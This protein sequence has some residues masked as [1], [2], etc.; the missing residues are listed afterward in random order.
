M[1]ARHARRDD[2]RARR[3]AASAA[4]PEPP[5]VAAA[6]AP[7][8]RGPHRRRSS[9]HPPRRRLR[10]SLPRRRGRPSEQGV[11]AATRLDAA[12]QSEP[13]VTTAA[14]APPQPAQPRRAAYGSLP[15]CST[16]DY[17]CCS[18][19]PPAPSVAAVPARRADPNKAFVPPPG[20]TPPGQAEPVAATAAAAP[21]GRPHLRLHRLTCTR[22]LLLHRLLRVGRSALRRRSLLRRRTAD[23]SKAFVPP[24]GWVPPGQSAATVAA[25]EAPPA[26]PPPAPAPVTTMASPP[27]PPLRSPRQHR[28]RHRSCA[29]AYGRSQQGLRAAAWLDSA[30]IG[31]PATG[32]C[33]SAGGIFGRSGC[34]PDGGDGRAA[35]ACCAATRRAA[36]G[37]TFTRQPA[38]RRD[39]VR[40]GLCRP[41]RQ[42]LRHPAE[43]GGDPEEQPRHG[44]H[45]RPRAAGRRGS[46]ADQAARANYEVSRQRAL[47]VANQL[48]RLGV[49]ANRIV[50]EAASDAEP[51][52][53]TTSAR[54]IAANRRA[55]IFVDF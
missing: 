28:R 36:A 24:P 23:P 1:P 29:G 3:A 16:A 7:A 51:A 53:E 47:A 14:A 55:E 9:Q 39:P 15:L 25:A 41:H 11:R 12:G 45:R 21:P 19:P 26:A 54:G 30:W 8:R 38:G 50:A 35:G 31:R 46:S 40:R 33:R 34:R 42:R 49:P 6:P 18:P 27:P 10:P 52:F 48:V 4:T 2:E 32:A 44:A 5:P 22:S 13:V 43:G 20:W 17:E 37:Y